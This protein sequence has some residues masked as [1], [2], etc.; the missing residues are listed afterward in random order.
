VLGRVAL[1][2]ALLL[3]LSVT[4]P[5][6]ERALALARW[7]HTDAERARFHERYLTVVGSSSGP[8][9]VTPVVLQL[10]VITEFRRVELLAE[11]HDRVQDLFGRGGTDDVVEALRPWRGTIAIGAYILLPGGKHAPVPPIDIAVAGAGTQPAHIAARTAFHTSSGLHSA[12]AAFVVD[13]VFDAAAI[14]QT[15]RDVRV[16]VN[17]RELAGARIDFST[18][19]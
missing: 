3:N 8:V 14:G 15:A 7:P 2:L 16:I 9:A 19:E 10:E 5:D 12:S 18:L 11:E 4:R 13:A 6:I 1:S 17:G